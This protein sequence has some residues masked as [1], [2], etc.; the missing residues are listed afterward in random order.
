[1]LPNEVLIVVRWFHFLAGITWIGLLYWF[2]LVN[3]NFMKSLD[4]TT[5]PLVVPALLPRALFWFRHSAWVTV[6]VG[7][8]LV[9][10]LYWQTNRI[11]LVNDNGFKTIFSGML[12]GLVMLF[13]VWMI[14]WPNQ[15]RT[16]AALAAGEAPD[17]AWARNTL[18]AS[19][20]NVTLS[21]PMLFFMGSASHFPLDW[22]QIV[23]V[24]VV[25]G[26]IG[27]S[28]VLYVQKW[29]AARF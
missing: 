5:R 10:G 2:N 22:P 17:P 7:F 19:R 11:D 12:L 1:M 15:R 21:F 3:V 25:A 4:A 16:F 20:A 27:L 24:A 8:V 13:N 14:I 29:A 18:Y 23:L 26:A 9:Y 28:A 6:L